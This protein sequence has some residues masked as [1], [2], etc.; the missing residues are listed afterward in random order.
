MKT[1]QTS[2]MD[3]FSF[4]GAQCVTESMHMLFFHIFGE[5][6]SVA[7]KHGSAIVQRRLV[8]IDSSLPTMHLFPKK[9]DYNTSQ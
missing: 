6:E 5:L 9:R 3:D 8:I 1:K 2:I 7:C 4:A